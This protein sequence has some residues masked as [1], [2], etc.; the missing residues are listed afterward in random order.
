MKKRMGKKL[1][2][3]ST[4]PIRM[5]LLKAATLRMTVAIVSLTGVERW[6]PAWTQRSKQR[7]FVSA[8]EI[9]ARQ[10]GSAIPP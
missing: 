6:S 4:M 5:T 7:Y 9:G 3:S 1:K 8:T 10:E 2:I